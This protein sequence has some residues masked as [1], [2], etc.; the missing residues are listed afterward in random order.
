MRLDPD[1]ADEANAILDAY[2]E[3]GGNVFDTAEVYGLGR[4]ERALGQYFSRRGPRARDGAILVTKGAVSPELVRPDYLRRAIDGSRER[5]QTDCIDVYL[6][7]RDDPT[8]PVGELV[9]VLD[10]AATAGK[11]RA[12][13]GSNWSVSRLAAANEYAARHAKRPFQV[14]SPHVGLATPREPWWSGC[15]HATAADL[16]WYAE[17]GMAVLGW[18]TQGRGFFLRTAS[19]DARYGAELERVYGGPDNEEKRRRLL[20]LAAARGQAPQDLAV[21]YVLGLPVPLVA[22]VGPLTAAEMPRLL[23]IPDLSLTAEEARWLALVPGAAAP[24]GL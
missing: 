8:V 23:R 20:A 18:S 9:E 22:L 6:L 19:Y 2:I 7:H 24:A 1:R 11:L 4:S 21:A 3:G 17:V 14:S 12:F 13:G 5:L 10:E 16:A 15:T